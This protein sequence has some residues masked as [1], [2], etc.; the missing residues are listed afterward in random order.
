MDGFK[1]IRSNKSAIV[2]FL[3]ALFCIIYIKSFHANADY[4]GI[5]FD[6]DRYQC[7]AHKIFNVIV[8]ANPSPCQTKLQV[9]E[10]AFQGPGYPVM[11]APFFAFKDF[12]LAVSNLQLVL[13]VLGGFLLFRII[14][15]GS[16]LIAL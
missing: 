9:S 15:D 16:S 10:L 8:D 3:A 12:G 6:A 1:I 4:R 2:S 11:L 14:R 5:I 13:F 7:L